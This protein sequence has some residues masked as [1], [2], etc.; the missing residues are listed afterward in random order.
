MD[1]ESG[2]WFYDNTTKGCYDTKLTGHVNPTVD[3]TGM[4]WKSNVNTDEEASVGLKKVFMRV[5]DWNA[6]VTS[7]FCNIDNFVC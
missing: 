1:C 6:T 7:R 3:C 4:Y 5:L 2:W